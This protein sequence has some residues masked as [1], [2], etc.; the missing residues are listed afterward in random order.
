MTKRILVC[1]AVTFLLSSVTSAQT[2]ATTTDSQREWKLVWS[3]EFD[4]SGL[5]SKDKWDYEVGKIRNRESQYY[6]R[7]RSENTRVKDGHLVIE[8]RK[9]KYE[10]SDYTAGSLVSKA[11]WK[12]GRIEVRAK[13]PTG[14]GMWPAIWMMPRDRRGGW[15]ACGEIDI[16]EN[17]GFQPDIIHATVHTRSYNHVQ[18]TQKGKTI[19]TE[20]PYEKFCVYAIEWNE[21][22]ID[23]YLDDKKYFTF[24]NE[25]TGPSEW[26]F[27]KAFHLKLNI[28]VGGSWGGQQGIDDS[29]FPQQFVIDYVRVYQ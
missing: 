18:G 22:Q 8:A 20:K 11:D 14:R 10:K 15:P 4:Y 19:K 21:Q 17:V 28:A 12:Y 27:D 9:E 25:R 24:K 6:T 7:A 2:P 13:I 1:L 3:D 16:M 5:P 26:P 23:F 29:I